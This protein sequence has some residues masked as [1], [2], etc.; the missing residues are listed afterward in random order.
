[1]PNNEMLDQEVDRRE[2]RRKRRVKN[3][4]I[5]YI[6]LMIFLAGLI[7]GGIFGVN[8]IMSILKDKK[9]AEELQKQLEE[10]SD[11]EEEPPVVEAPEESAEPEGDKDY[12][13]EIVESSIA[14]MPLADKVAGLFIITPESLTDMDVVTRAGDTTREKL[15]EYRVGGLIYFSQNILDA[16]QLTEMLKNTRSWSRYSI[17]L[18]V[19]EE[20]GSVSRV[21][22]NGL[23]D[24]VGNMAEIGASGDTAADRKSVV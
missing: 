3:Q 5:A 11:P 1:M 15:D 12:L 2:Q 16:D 6:V 20:G 14:E 4:V 10:L 18:G 19:D 21:A 9:Q 17:F 7:V 8:K 22:G 23:A 13:G 24:G